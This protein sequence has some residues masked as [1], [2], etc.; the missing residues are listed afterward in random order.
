MYLSAL[1]YAHNGGELEWCF[2]CMFRAGVGAAGGGGVGGGSSA[3]FF[4]FGFDLK[5][6]GV[7]VH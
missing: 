6:V 3:W 2:W 4:S 1:G 5:N 7:G